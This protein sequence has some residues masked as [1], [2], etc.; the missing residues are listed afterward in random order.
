MG[1]YSERNGAGAG[2]TDLVNGFFGALQEYDYCLFESIRFDR[3][4]SDKAPSLLDATVA[5]MDR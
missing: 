5:A 3:P 1:D 2:A 4:L